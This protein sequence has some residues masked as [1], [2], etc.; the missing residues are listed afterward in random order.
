MSDLNKEELIRQVKAWAIKANP[1]EDYTEKEWQ[2]LEQIEQIIKLHFS[3]DWQQVKKDLGKFM[4]ELLK[5][6]VK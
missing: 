4:V 2:A 6:G 5:K 3:E 1:D